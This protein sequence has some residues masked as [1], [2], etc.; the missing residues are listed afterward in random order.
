MNYIQSRN[1]RHLSPDDRVSIEYYLKLHYSYSKIAAILG[2]NR[3]TISR[4]VKRGQVEQLNGHSW[5]MYKIYSADY[6]Q[7]DANYKATAKGRPEKIGKRFDYLTAL[8]SYVLDD[9]SPAAAIAAVYHDGK[10]TDIKITAATFYKYLRR[11]YFKRIRYSNLPRGALK[12]N[13]GKT[14]KIRTNHPY[15]RSIEQRSRDILLRS[16]LGHWELDSIIGK[17]SGKGQSCL[18]LTER[19]TRVEMVLKVPD[20]VAKATVDALRYLHSYFGSDFKHL[21]KTITCDNGT[22]FSDQIGMDSFG[23]PV[24][25]CH[26]SC[27]SERGSN[28]C[29]NLLVRRKFRK[30]ESLSHITQADARKVQHWVNN[31]PRPMFGYRSALDVFVD[32][33]QSIPL[34]NPDNVKRFFGISA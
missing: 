8:E 15:H 13:K 3:S 27:P 12:R 14:V 28:E 7:K 18:V 10:I 2:C 29:A 24:F 11:N 25:F 33:M 16:E 19:K 4:E 21:F 22:E 1:G 23:A 6:A 32:E 30:G 31:Y 20:K 26:P 9:Y 34:E 17:S 5:E